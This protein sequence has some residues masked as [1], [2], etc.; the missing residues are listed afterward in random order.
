V[1]IF[2]TRRR[3]GCGRSGSTWGRGKFPLEGRPN[4]GPEEHEQLITT[5]MGISRTISVH[6]II[7][8]LQDLIRL[9]T[10]A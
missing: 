10:L 1:G 3:R 2:T 9:Q 5:P 7:Q 4:I 6:M 8:N